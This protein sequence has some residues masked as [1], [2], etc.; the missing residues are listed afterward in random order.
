MKV[1]DESGKGAVAGSRVELG[2]LGLPVAGR[3]PVLIVFWK[4]L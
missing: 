1:L 3:G 2:E 4:R